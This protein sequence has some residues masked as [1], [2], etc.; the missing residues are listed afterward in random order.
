MPCDLCGSQDN[1]Q[2]KVV[3]RALDALEAAR[4]GTKNIMLAALQNVRPS[5]LIDKGLWRSLGLAAA[6]ERD[7]DGGVIAPSRLVRP[8][9][10]SV[11]ETE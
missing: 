8:R 11:S 1:L 10:L 4:P 7:D 2:R 3:G 6:Q 9:G 5:Q